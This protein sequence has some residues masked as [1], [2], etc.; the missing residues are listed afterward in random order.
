MLI[1]M[2]PSTLLI[3]IVDF[4]DGLWPTQRG[5]DRAP[6]THN[7]NNTGPIYVHMFVWLLNILAWNTTS[8]IDW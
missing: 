7:A 8:L 4:A 5:L 2:T 6:I 3:D 1:M